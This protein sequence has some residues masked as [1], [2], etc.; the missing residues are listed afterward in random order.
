[1]YRIV[2][3]QGETIAISSRKE[4]A[5]AMISTQLDREKLKIIVDIP[6]N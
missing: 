4:D 5:V 2:N 1:M 6:K 3:E